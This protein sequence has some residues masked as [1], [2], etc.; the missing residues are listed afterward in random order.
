MEENKVCNK[1][2]HK[3]GIVRITC[4]T[5]YYDDNSVLTTSEPIG[6]DSDIKF[7]PFCGKK[8]LEVGYAIK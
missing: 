7:C 1:Y 2:T 3:N 4:R 6:F 8:L 5:N